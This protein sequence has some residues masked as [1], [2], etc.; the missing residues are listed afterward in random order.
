MRF[1]RLYLALLGLL[2][3]ATLTVAPGCKRGSAEEKEI[4]ELSQKAAE[5]DKLS[6]QANTTGGSQAQKLQQAGVTDIKPN[7]ETLQLT[8]EQKKALEERIKAEK[9]SSYQALLQEVLE[10]DKEIKDL[11]EKISKLRAAL[12]KPDLAK[13]GDSHYG[14]ALRFLKKKGV[15]DEEAKRLI[16]RV[17]IMEKLAAGFEVYHFYANG[18]YGSWVSQGKA[19][20]TP[21]DLVREEREKVEGERD[22]AIAQSEKLQEEVNDL[23]TQKKQIEE[24]IAG[25]RTE[26]AK[27][28]DEMNAL[29]ATNEKQKSKLNS[30]HYLVGERKA[31]EQKGVIIIPVFAKDRSGA[32]WTDDLFDHDLDLRS[33]DELKLTAQEAGVKKIGKVN[34]VPGSLV[35]DEH[36][37]LTISEDKQSATIKIL[38]KDRFRNEKVVFA[39]SE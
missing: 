5:L 30:L 6:Q 12:P 29:S 32:K 9:N 11:N 26:K 16:S 21:N 8:E 13:P 24:E 39:V 37:R 36:Y 25:L 2:T 27:L 14:M 35:K 28:M 20:I 1:P 38:A 18:V 23:V 22:T 15:N 7:A 33:S 31:L 10:K 17:N 3:V 34:V 19:K 4:K